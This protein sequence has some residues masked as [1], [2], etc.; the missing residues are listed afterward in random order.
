M[1]VFLLCITGPIFAISILFEDTPQAYDSLVLLEESYTGPSPEVSNNNNLEEIQL[2]FYGPG[3]NVYEYYGHVGIILKYTG[4]HEVLYDWG[5]FNSQ[6]PGFILNAFRGAMFYELSSSNPKQLMHELMQM[7]GRSV[8]YYTLEGLSAED[9]KFIEGFLVFNSEPSNSRYRYHF[10]EDNC[11]TRVR[12]LLNHV[13]DGKLKE[14]YDIPY[15]TRRNAIQ[16]QTAP[17]I[18][19]ETLFGIGQGSV[20]DREISYYDAMFLP[21]FLEEGLKDLKIENE[22]GELVSPLLL[23]EES[24]W[25]NKYPYDI[26]FDNKNSSWMPIFLIMGLIAALNI[27]LNLF[28]TKL[29]FSKKIFLGLNFVILIPLSLISL[30]LFIA[31]FYTIHDCVWFNQN[32]FFLNPLSLILLFYSAKGL[33]TRKIKREN[34]SL[35]TISFVALIHVILVLLNVVLKIFL[36]HQANWVHIVSFGLYFLSLIQLR[37]LKEFIMGLKNFKCPL[38]KNAKFKSIFSR[39]EK[40]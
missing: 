14:K 26:S 23:K 16:A 36:P 28:S 9:K 27:V 17:H 37:D 25:E 1:L 5:V 35:S 20:Q 2:V 15:G 31:P 29:R 7:E 11:S 39:K 19:I 12:D 40:K 13:Y 34:T 6:T 33:F 8:R 21:G 10:F 24:T 38:S 3:K 4:V 30:I 32:T 22:N 18:L